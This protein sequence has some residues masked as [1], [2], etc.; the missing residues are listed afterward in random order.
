MTVEATNI[1]TAETVPKYLADRADRIGVFPA[2]AKL[3][4]QAIAGGNVNYAFCVTSEMGQTVFVKQAPEY[5]AVFGPDGLPL[6]SQRMRQEYN[7]YQEWSRVLGDELSAKYLPRIHYLDDNNMVF[8]MDFLNG[9]SLLD[10]D[11]VEKGVVPAKIAQGLADFMSRVHFATHSS[12]IS[13]EKAAEFTKEYENRAMRDIQL[14]FVFTK[15]YKEATEEQRAGLTVDGAFLAEI[16]QLKAAYD[17]KNTGNLCLTHGDLHPGSVMVNE[18][19][20]VKVIDPEFT[21][22]GPPGLDVGSLLS[23]YVLAAVHQ[24][25]VPN[26]RAVKTLNEAAHSVWEAYKAGLEKAGMDQTLIAETE[27]DTVGF[28]VAEVCRTALGFAGGRL[29]LQFEDPEVK[30]AA[31]QAAM[32]IV[33]KC[34]IGR[35]SGG[36]KL[37]WTALDEIQAKNDTAA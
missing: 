28:T 1:L 34:M 35:H 27:V 10:H 29:W 24:A 2:D 36:I 31:I 18:E 8:V 32:V 25:Y 11:L 3:S 22:Y 15:C 21:C 19:G 14:E 13:P 12:Q 9:Y 37:L 30:K 20:A 16:D 5:V 4:A 23:G 17:G 26:P 6:T 33:G 7:V